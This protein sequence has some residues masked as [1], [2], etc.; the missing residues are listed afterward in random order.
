MPRF[1]V[2]REKS[3]GKDLPQE[4]VNKLIDMGISVG[5]RVT[6]IHP[7]RTKA[8]PTS[9]RPAARHVAEAVLGG[10]IT[11][12]QGRDLNRHYLQFMPI[13]EQIADSKPKKTRKKAAPKK[14]AVKSQDYEI[15]VVNCREF[16]V[17]KVPEDKK[18]MEKVRKEDR[19]AN[20]SLY[21]PKGIK[22]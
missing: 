7:K 14:K 10:H 5:S 12:E 21:R 17:Y 4:E 19:A 2:P 18:A 6:Y 11:R 8:N 20:T 22:Y 16:K 15:R 9:G 13:T 3:R 1:I